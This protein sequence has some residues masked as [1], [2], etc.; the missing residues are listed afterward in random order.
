MTPLC[1]YKDSTIVTD[2][3]RNVIPPLMSDLHDACAKEEMKVEA[4]RQ[5][6]AKMEVKLHAELH[7]ESQSLHVH[8]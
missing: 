3:T 2:S 4:K 8:G 7:L 5:L 1:C 6:E